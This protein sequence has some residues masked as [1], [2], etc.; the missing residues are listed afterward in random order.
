ML[1]KVHVLFAASIAYAA[2]LEPEKIAA[3]AAFGVV[4]D[5]DHVIGLKHRSVTHSL[6]FSFA[7][8]VLLYAIR[9][10]FIIASQIGIL[11]HLFADMFTK[12]GVPLLYPSVKRFRIANFRYDSLA[13][14]FMIVLIS[15]LLIFLKVR[16]TTSL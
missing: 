14:N 6:I 7:I 11:S 5:L 3:A 13:G 9:P 16:A 8:G 12:G 15:A 1:K 2:G 4:S 10:D